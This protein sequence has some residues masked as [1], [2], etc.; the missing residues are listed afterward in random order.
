MPYTDG[1]KSRMVQ[2]MAG[3]EGISATALSKEVGISQATLSRWLHRARTVTLMGGPDNQQKRARS[4]RQWGPDEKL[5]VVLE[6]AKLTD[7]EL[8][9]FLRRK[10]LH[11]AQ[12]EEWREL[13]MSAL[14]TSKRARSRQASSESKRIRMLEKELH[15][16][17]KALA[18][19][20][21]LLVLKKKLE[22]IWGG[23]A[24]DT[25]TKNGT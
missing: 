16:K 15:R 10:G 23:E 2:R 6:A 25:A 4:P 7:A 17:D 24:D 9:A 19:V 5:Q 20:T 8:G 18:E 13:V 11:A 3:P 1:L 22:T 14:S 12:L 21:A